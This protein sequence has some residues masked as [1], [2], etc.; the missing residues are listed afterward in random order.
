MFVLF[1]YHYFSYYNKGKK[2]QTYMRLYEELDQYAR[3]VILMFIMFLVGS[4]VLLKFEGFYYVL[5]KGA[6]LSVVVIPVMFTYYS[7]PDRFLFM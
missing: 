5:F 2:D 3:S 4:Y 6:V 1:I 7:D